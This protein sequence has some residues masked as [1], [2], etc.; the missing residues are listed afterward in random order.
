MVLKK[1]YPAPLH[2]QMC[3][4][5]L[6]RVLKL[7]KISQMSFAEYHSKRNFVECVHAEENRVL[8]KHRPFGS[9][10]DLLLALM[11]TGKTWNIWQM[12]LQSVYQTA[13]FGEKKLCYATQAST[14]EHACLTGTYNIVPPRW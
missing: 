4:A 6:L 7:H 5:C 12:R 1:N 3:M 8:S 9:Q 11:S 2:V 13:T 10:K 14:C